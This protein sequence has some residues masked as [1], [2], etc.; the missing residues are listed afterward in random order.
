MRILFAG[1]VYARSGRDAIVK[2]IPELRKKLLPDVVIVNGE[3]SAHGIGITEK[4]CK[5]FYEVGVDIITTGNHVWDQQEILAYIK[6]DERL[7]R[8]INYPQDTPGKGFVFFDTPKGERILAINAM[9]RLFMDQLDDPFK[10]VHDLVT[11]HK[12]G[13][14]CDAIFVDLHGETTAEKMA[15]AHYLDGKV[16]AVVGTHTHIPTSDAQ[17]FDGGTAFQCDAGM[18]GNYNSVIGVKP[19]VPVH[20]FT[21]RTPTERKQP[22][23]GEA[24]LCGVLIETGGNG[25]AKNIAP[26]RI[27]GRLRGEIPDF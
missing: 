27:G 24:T 22:A 16:S 1:D 4:I 2:Y 14:Q 6:R 13:A 15:F 8:P 19:N 3:N 5:E 20:R 26:I 9:A 23:D 17:I 18:T 21:K 10:A 11:E 25:L 7:L 12:L